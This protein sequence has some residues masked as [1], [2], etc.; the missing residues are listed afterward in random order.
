VR[1]SR[2]QSWR[3]SQRLS[4]MGRIARQRWRSGV[5]LP[6]AAARWP[7]ARRPS[8]RSHVVAMDLL[9]QR[10]RR[11]CSCVLR[12]H[13]SPRVPIRACAPDIRFARSGSGHRWSARAGVRHCR[14]EHR[15]MGLHP[16]SWV[17]AL[18]GALLAG[19]LVIESR[20]PAPLVRLSIF[21]LGSL[22]AA[23]LTILLAS[24]AVFSTF[25]FVSLYIQQIL[26][27]SR[28]APARRSF[29]SRREPRR[30]PW[31]PA[32]SSHGSAFERCP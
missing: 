31:S 23:D 26:G 13:G 30:A 8:Y 18:G 27:Y 25:F 2:R 32:G 4:P 15:G 16:H 10:A 20:S 22:A 5:G 3:S 1:C 19:F 24:A 12:R 11:C 29:P 28:C 21:R 14:I 6:L 9:R 17:V 7:P